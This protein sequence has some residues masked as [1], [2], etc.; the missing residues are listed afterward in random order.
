MTFSIF[1][2]RFRNS[3]MKQAAL[4]VFA[5]ISL[6]LV[7]SAQQAVLPVDPRVS[8]KPEINHPLPPTPNSTAPITSSSDYVLG[9]GDLISVIVTDLEDD[10]TDKTFRVDMSGDLTLP[11]AGR[12]HASG[13]TTE[14]LELA[15]SANL[16]KIIKQPD[17][18][19]G[20]AEFHSQAVSVLGEVNTAGEYQ[21]QGQKKLLE[22]ISLAGGF[23]EDVGN[24]VT[25]TR[26]LRWGRIPLSNAHDDATAQ[27]SIAS[28]S[29]KSILHAKNPEQN[30]QMMPNDVISV[31]KAEIVYVVGAV[32]K[33][34]GF[35]M[36]Q[37]ETLSALQVISLAEGLTN[38]ASTQNAKIIRLSQGSN[39]RT[40][41]AVN[42]KQ[43]LQG[44]AADVPLQPGDI[45]FVPNSAVKS[46]SARSIQAIVAA[47]T[48]IVVYGRY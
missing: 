43:L 6:A 18:T 1:E 45:L 48:G 19:V 36:G 11:Y 17:V 34:G 33:P 13:L 21:V 4:V 26:D 2:T 31:S 39:A 12:V 20:V 30:I 22:A 25:I 9:P 42:L 7:S 16:S 29:V 28:V 5:L 46:A 24:T 47:A 38:V 10:F 32:T 27:F 37:D 44:R 23:T 3:F 15:I 8:A 40:E 35:P 14:Q 41:L